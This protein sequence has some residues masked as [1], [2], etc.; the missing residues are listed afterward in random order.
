VATRAEV[1]FR[2]WEVSK[3]GAKF[4]DR[5]CYLFNFLWGWRMRIG[6]HQIRGHGSVVMW[7]R[8]I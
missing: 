4:V 2:D 5:G 6:R 7:L 3:V 8:V 1:R